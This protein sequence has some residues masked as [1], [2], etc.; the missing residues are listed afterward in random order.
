[1]ICMI[2]A[3]HCI[4]IWHRETNFSKLNG[5]EIKDS[6]H[7]NPNPPLLGHWPVK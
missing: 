5:M 1:M 7:H 2:L 3:L 6:L 4:I